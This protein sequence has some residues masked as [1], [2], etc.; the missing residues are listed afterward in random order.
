MAQ[1]RRDYF[2]LKDKEVSQVAREWENT[3]DAGKYD[4][5]DLD[6]DEG[7]YYGTLNGE[8]MQLLGA[9][10]KATEEQAEDEKPE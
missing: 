4:G 3:G 1:L 9:C 2:R 6:F 7:E 8:E 10:N 5:V